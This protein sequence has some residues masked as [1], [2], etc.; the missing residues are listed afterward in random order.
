[1]IGKNK[2]PNNPSDPFG[3]PILGWRVNLAPLPSGLSEPAP[4]DVNAIARKSV[5]GG[6]APIDTVRKVAEHIGVKLSDRDVL[7]SDFK[8]DAVSKVDPDDDWVSFASSGP[9]LSR[10]IAIN[11][12]AEPGG[13]GPDSGEVVIRPW[14]VPGEGRD[15]VAS[16]PDLPSDFVIPD[17]DI[18]NDGGP[19]F[20]PE[21][22]GE[23]GGF[24]DP[25]SINTFDELVEALFQG[26][27]DLNDRQVFTD[28]VDFEFIRKSLG[29][30]AWTQKFRELYSEINN[31]WL[32]NAAEA[33][34]LDETDSDRVWAEIDAKGLSNQEVLVMYFFGKD[35]DW[36]DI[37]DKGLASRLI[38]H[39]LTGIRHY[40]ESALIV[41]G[42]VG[43]APFVSGNKDF[44]AVS[45]SQNTDPVFGFAPDPVEPGA[46]VISGSRV[47]TL[48]EA[49]AYLDQRGIRPDSPAH[50]RMVS[51]SGRASAKSLGRLAGFLASTPNRLGLSVA[52]STGIYDIVANKD[53]PFNSLRDAGVAVGAYLLGNGVKRALNRVQKGESYGR[54]RR[55]GLSRSDFLRQRAEGRRMA[56][57][58]AIGERSVPVTPRSAPV[59]PPTNNIPSFSSERERRIFGRDELLELL[60]YADVLGVEDARDSMAGNPSV[61]KYASELAEMQ[62]RVGIENVISLAED[63]RLEA[64]AE[65]E[66]FGVSPG[67]YGHSL[68]WAVWDL[69]KQA[70]LSKH[71]EENG[72]GYS[73]VDPF[74]AD[75]DERS[76]M[77]REIID[78]H[79][80]WELDEKVKSGVVV[81][82]DYY[83]GI[84]RKSDGSLSSRDYAKVGEMLRN[85]SLKL[86]T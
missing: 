76:R 70:Y 46:A 73:P 38:S 54:L 59:S 24:E 10:S 61:E 75:S 71:P 68:S 85:G 77:L 55:G 41:D 63:L 26:R 36:K 18:N 44:P 6:D 8:D 72:E 22:G 64:L 49:Q 13:F 60:I 33:L 51:F 31:E 80:G 82:E 45:G 7:E 30:N 17:P 69:A 4:E 20:A 37:L 40:I 74:N 86:K 83:P 42:G 32:A 53:V 52:G 5:E 3:A 16:T 65:L 25:L 29:D 19:N 12:P 27:L 14:V 43:P 9:S 48:E 35:Q 84:V 58:R 34:G 50:R 39:K 78:R 79:V 56:S 66:R 21:K 1:M 28:I 23:D 47:V 2:T 67:I 57:G 81:L 11:E 62:R 15:S